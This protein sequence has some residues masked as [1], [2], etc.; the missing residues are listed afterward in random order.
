MDKCTECP[1]C[2]CSEYTHKNE[3]GNG[4]RVCIEC[5]QEWYS[6]INYKKYSSPS[7]YYEVFTPAGRSLPMK[8]KSGDANRFDKRSVKRRIRRLL[9]AGWV[10]TAFVTKPSQK[11]MMIYSSWPVNPMDSIG[12]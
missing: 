10:V 9:K 7:Y 2:G 12:I 6:T 8:D 1:E 4:Y 3:L 11:R 5:Q